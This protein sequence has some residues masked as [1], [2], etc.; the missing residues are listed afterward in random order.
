MMAKKQHGGPRKGAGRPPKSDPLIKRTIA[1]NAA[2]WA[3]F[4]KLKRK[5]DATNPGLIRL[6]V[7][8]RELST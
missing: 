2:D 4:D 7:A 8:M 6:L 1:M 5:H 3:A